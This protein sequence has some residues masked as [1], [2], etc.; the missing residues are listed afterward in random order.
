MAQPCLL[1]P[2]PLGDLTQG[3]SPVWQRHEGQ[4][5]QLVQKAK[6]SCFGKTKASRMHTGV[7]K[8]KLFSYTS[9]LSLT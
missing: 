3:R 9:A 6:E 1:L 7:S 4:E 5:Q 2:G 8:D